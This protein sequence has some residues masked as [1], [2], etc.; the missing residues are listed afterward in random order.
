MTTSPQAK[1]PRGIRDSRS[2]AP[3]SNTRAEPRPPTCPSATVISRAPSAMAQ[4]SGQ[5]FLL[6]AR[7]PQLASRKFET[8]LGSSAQSERLPN[9]QG[10]RHLSFTLS[11]WPWGSR[12]T[13]S[14]PSLHILS[15]PYLRA[16]Q[17]GAERLRA[18]LAPRQSSTKVG[19]T[20]LGVISLLAG[21]PTLLISSIIP[22]TQPLRRSEPW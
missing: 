4:R 11:G 15:F 8:Q 16:W 2:I 3:R 22:I 17:R 12:C 6:I 21:I 20:C 19:N 5:A 18:R 7:N 10:D 1:A 9:D 14:I 13:S